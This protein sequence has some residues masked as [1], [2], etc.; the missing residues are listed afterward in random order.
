MVV[1]L[2]LAVV[3]VGFSVGT[4]GGAAG[5]TGAVVK[6]LVTSIDESCLSGVSRGGLELTPALVGEMGAPPPT[7]DGV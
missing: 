1:A 7:G 5:A 2:V 6:L 3:S 4:A